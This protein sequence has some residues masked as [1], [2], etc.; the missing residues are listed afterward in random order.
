MSGEEVE[1]EGTNRGVSTTKP[2][3]RGVR[4]WVL[5]VHPKVNS[6]RA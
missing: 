4:E 1:K 5:V 3:L 2:I 6:K